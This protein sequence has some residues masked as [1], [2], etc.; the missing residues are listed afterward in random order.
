MKIKHLVSALVF[1][2]IVS[3]GCTGPSSESKAEDR[4]VANQ[5]LE[6]ES[7]T[8]HYSYML[9]KDY[10][11][12]QTY[13]L[14]IT[15]PGYDRM[16]LSEDSKEANLD[17]DGFT[18]WANLN[19]DMIVVSAQ[20]TDWGETSALQAIDLMEYFIEHFPVNTRRIYA[21]GYSVGGETMSRAVSMRPDLYAAYLHGASQW[22][23]TFDSIAQNRVAVYIYMAQSDGCV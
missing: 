1:S 16:W 8:V 9:P 6:L 18:C 20:L 4:L 19:E 15:M 17:W 12:E 11:E 5:V 13:P 7:G 14:M 23:G 21:N 22:D 3:T 10:D 2:L